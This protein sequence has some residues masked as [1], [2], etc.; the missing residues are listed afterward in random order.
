MLKLYGGARSRASIVRWYLEELGADY[1]FVFLD[2]QAGEHKQPDFL[3]L[4]PFGK[5]PVLTDDEV[6]LFESG[7]ILLYLA[8]KFGHLGPSPADKAIAYQWVLFAN[9]TFSMGLTPAENRNE[10]MARYLQPLNDILQNTAF[11][12]GE[13]FTVADVAVGSILAY[14]P[15]MFQDVDLSA[16][17]ALQAYLKRLGDRPAFQK[18]I[19]NRG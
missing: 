18:A 7:A 19:M 11:L 2:M 5:V 17:P 13:A 12:L 1:E 3:A 14:I 9:S 4:N 6:T 16:Y 10:V 8:E 15:L